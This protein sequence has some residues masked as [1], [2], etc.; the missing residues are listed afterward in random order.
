M[1]LDEVIHLM[2]IWGRIN[3]I[4]GPRGIAVA[5]AIVVVFI[6]EVGVGTSDLPCYRVVGVGC[7]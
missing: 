1:W 7:R 6:V 3:L 5:A 4:C 2:M